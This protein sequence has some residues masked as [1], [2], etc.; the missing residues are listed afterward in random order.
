MYIGR[1]S[2]EK[3]I[4][5][6]LEML[7]GYLKYRQGIKFLLVGGGADMNILKQLSGALGIGT[8]VIFTGEKPWQT[9]GRYC[10][11]GDVFISASQSETQ[12]LTYV[13][14]L[15]SG[16]PIV[17][18]ADR[19]LKDVLIEGD[20]GFSFTDKTSLHKA[21]DKILANDI[22]RNA[23]GICAIKSAEKFTASHYAHT[24]SELYTD[25]I[26]K[27]RSPYNRHGKRAFA[28]QRR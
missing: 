27:W 26:S 5:K 13:E 22:L 12:G 14:A 25:V 18:K 9:I 8:Q 2:K 7:S 16:L 20:N 3:S 1:I 24:V 17:A 23:M 19:C 21:L 15:A 10:K 11:M 28:S 4:D 6:L